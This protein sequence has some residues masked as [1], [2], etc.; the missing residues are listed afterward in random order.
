MPESDPRK[1]LSIEEHG[2]Q[3]AKNLAA[4]TEQHIWH[5]LAS[6]QGEVEPLHTLAVRAPIEHLLLS[7]TDPT[8]HDLFPA[9]LATSPPKLLTVDATIYEMES[10]ATVDRLLVLLR[11][12]AAKVTILNLTVQ[13]QGLLGVHVLTVRINHHAITVS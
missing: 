12:I 1:R 3:I 7:S 6:L 10:L 2:R 8:S 4:Q 9:I 11:H 5:S 13:F